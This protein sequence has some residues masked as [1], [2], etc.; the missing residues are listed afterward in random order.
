MA[1]RFLNIDV[2]RPKFLRKKLTRVLKKIVADHKKD[3]GD[4]AVIFC[5]DEYLLNIN[6]E[7]LSH[8]FFTDVITFDYCE[9]D[10]ISGDIF[11]S[12][13]RIKE[14][15]KEYKA[16]IELEIVRVVCHGVLHLLGYKDKTAVQKGEMTKME[17]KMIKYW[18][19]LR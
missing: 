8:D 19:E 5:D 16:T 7:H 9:E 12:I 11:I 3:L 18:H 4:I 1:I 13:D 14:N 6:K 10:L 15:A 17:E 2:V